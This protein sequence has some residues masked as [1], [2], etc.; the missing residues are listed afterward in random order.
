TLMVEKSKLD[1][2]LQGKPVDATQYHEKSKLDEDLQGKPI[3]ATLYCGMIGSLMYLTSSRPELTYA[4]CLYARYQAKHT[5]KHLNAVKQVFRYLKGTINMSLCHNRRDLPRDIPL[6]SVEV[7]RFDKRSKVRI[8]KECRLRWSYYWNKPNKT[9]K[10]ILATEGVNFPKPPPLRTPK[11]RRMENGLDHLVKNIKERKDKQKSGGKKDIPKDKA[12]TI[13]MVQSWQRKTRQK[14]FTSV[15]HPQTNGLVE[16]ANRSLGEGIK[17][18]LDKHKGRWVEELSHVLWEHRTTIKVSTGDTPFSLIYETEAVIPAETGMPTIRTTEVNVVTNDDERQ[19]DLDLLEERHE[20]AAI[21]KA[22]AK[23]KMK[24]YYDAK[25][26]G[27]SFRPGDFV[28]HANGASHAKDAGKLGPKW[29]G[30]YEVTEALGN[31][32]YKLRDMDG[33]ELPRT[34]NICNLKRC[35]L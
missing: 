2:D 31:G 15:K 14:H 23:S 18:R 20:R 32:A 27:V 19:I 13:Y 10:E 22:K 3:N 7:L 35:Y 28:Y 1:E 5:E 25:V 4:V 11:E 8:R 16:R 9:P 12:D 30:P 6:Y 24:G 26:R 17:A 21:C 29:E 33:R 34:W